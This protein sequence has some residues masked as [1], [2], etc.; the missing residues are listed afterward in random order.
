MSINRKQVAIANS[1]PAIIE[2]QPA[3]RQALIAQAGEAVAVVVAEAGLT[4]REQ[5]IVMSIADLYLQF[6]H[7]DE[8]N[9]KWSELMEASI[10]RE[11]AEK[12]CRVVQ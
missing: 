11:N 1:L 5:K 9:Q 2:S 8:S 3:S 12:I 10:G 7:E 6:F 4:I